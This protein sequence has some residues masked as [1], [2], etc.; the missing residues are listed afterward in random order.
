MAPKFE[1]KPRIPITGTHKEA[2]EKLQE[3]IGLF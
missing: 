3:K 1:Y 2:K